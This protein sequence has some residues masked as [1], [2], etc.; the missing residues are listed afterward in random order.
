MTGLELKPNLPDLNWIFVYYNLVAQI[1]FFIKISRKFD[2]R[3]VP[4]PHSTPNASASTRKIRNFEELLKLYV[5]RIMHI[6][7]LPASNH[8]N[9]IKSI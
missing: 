9:C 7:L 4:K 3:Q 1:C 2:K 5:R 6:T 8:L